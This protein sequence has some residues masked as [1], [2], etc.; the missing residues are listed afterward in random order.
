MRLSCILSL[1]LLPEGCATRQGAS[2][3]VEAASSRWHAESVLREAR[4]EAAMLRHE[5]A[6][7]RIAAAKKE[8]E[9]EEL[10]RQVSAFRQRETD[11]RQKRTEQQQMIEV[12]Q[13]E[14]TALRAEFDRVL[15]ARTGIHAQL[16]DLPP[17]RQF[18]TEAS[19]IEA[20]GRVRID[21]LESAVAGLKAELDQ[22]KR[23][24]VPPRARP[25]A[26]PRDAAAAAEPALPTRRP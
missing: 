3:A 11:L 12:K 10:R 7:A 19:A 2:S 4:N 5:I 9:L 21:A 8:A 26:K 24:L 25:A 1:A 22:V 6:S 23:N 14:L 13:T 15:Q 17:P 18:L 16:V 20:R